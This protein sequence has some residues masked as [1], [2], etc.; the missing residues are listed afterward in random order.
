[1][2]DRIKALLSGRTPAPGAN[3]REDLTFACVMLLAEAARM[4][5]AIDERE[6]GAMERLLSDRFSLGRETARALIDAAIKRADGSNRF[7]SYTQQVKDGLDAEGR[8]R[9]VEMLWEVVLADGKLDP[10]EDNLLRRVAGLIHVSD[11]ESGAAR[12][13]VKAR[14][15]AAR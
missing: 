7:F 14:L 15:A 8:I 11:A 5:E 6:I 13:R 9:M 3:A 4:D 2:I 1:M 10:Y 12:Q